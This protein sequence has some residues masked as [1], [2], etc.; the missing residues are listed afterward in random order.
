[1]SRFSDRRDLGQVTVD[2]Q[3]TPPQALVGAPQTSGAAQA[4]PVVPQRQCGRFVV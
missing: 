2:P 4:A 3:Q 1:M